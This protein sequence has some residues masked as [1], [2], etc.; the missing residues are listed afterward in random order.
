MVTL[1]SLST[2]IEGANRAYRDYRASQIEPGAGTGL[3]ARDK[4]AQAA[5]ALHLADSSIPTPYLGNCSL[6]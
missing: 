4:Q 2:W 5:F 6:P 1:T 3:F